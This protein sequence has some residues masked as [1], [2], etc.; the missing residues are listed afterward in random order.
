LAFSDGELLSPGFDGRVGNRNTPPI[1]N[2]A[3]NFQNLFWDGRISQLTAMVTMPIFNHVE[4]GV[5]SNEYLLNNVKAQPYYT[6]LFNEAF[7]NQEITLENMGD[8]L[9]NF[10]AS[11]NSNNSEFD[12]PQ[13][14]RSFEVNE[15][16]KLF[17]GKYNCGNCHNVRDPKG[18]NG[19][20]QITP[21][22][23][24]NLTKEEI[25]RFNQANA[26]LINIGLDM[27]YADKGK[28]E[29]TGNPEDNGKFKIPNLR[30]VMLTAPY[31]HDGRFKTIDD[32]L[33]F[34]SKG[35]VSHP[36]L[37]ERLTTQN[38]KP[39]VLEITDQERLYL[40]SFLN[41]LTDQSF[42]SDPKFSDPF[43]NI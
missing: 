43:V 38:S 22:T 1:Q 20:G 12:R 9:T 41:A 32:V 3:P 14:E 18:Y 24:T 35:V 6:D 27:N 42:I 28:A 10:I 34:Y 25:I 17:F 13:N 26:S 15:G 21:E 40:K 11:L 4:M 36:N 33:D 37:D 23:N 16:E 2:I 5:K 30:N 8:A 39:Q 29:I 31:M 19:G 7:P